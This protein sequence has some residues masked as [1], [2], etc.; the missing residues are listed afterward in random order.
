MF[1]RAV[2]RC[3]MV[4]HVGPGRT[5]GAV[6]DPR[7]GGAAPTSRFRPPGCKRLVDR[8]ATA[9]TGAV[10]GMLVVGLAMA[11]PVDAA[12]GEQ[13]VE[14]DT[15]AGPIVV[16]IDVRHAP[17]TARNFLAYV[18]EHRFDGTSFYRAAR[19]KRDPNTG[20]VQGGVQHNARR[21]K[22]PIAHEPTSITGLRHVDGTLSMA[23]YEP[24]S[25]AGDFIIV[26]GGAP[27]LDARRGDPGYAAFG[28][29]V[30]GMAIV[31]R[32]LVQPTFPGGYTADT[33]NQTLRHPIVIRHAFRVK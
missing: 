18:D 32:M 13:R 7:I 12:P 14:L 8:L 28:H 4:S 5:S 29:V 19:G 31:R 24:G 30:S 20:F 11:A 3:T 6:S 17:I 21:S 15:S 27:H 26:V 23:R 16:A 25:A 9:S 22:F 1:E 2:D 33:L 10:A